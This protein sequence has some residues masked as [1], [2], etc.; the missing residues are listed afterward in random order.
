MAT[1]A[2]FCYPI[3]PIAV[4]QAQFPQMQRTT[5]KVREGT[6]TG[7]NLMLL[8][9]R[10]VA[11]ASGDDPARLRGPQAAP[12]ARR[13]AGLGAAGPDRAGAG[14]SPGLLPVATLEAG[15]SRLLGCRAAAVVT[16][17]AEIGTDVDKPEDVAAARAML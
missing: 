4:C 17:F 16:Q 2:D 11:D 8:N 13:D 12:A 1:G 6:F 15:V 9:R 7:G 10:A 3:I 5:L 14:V